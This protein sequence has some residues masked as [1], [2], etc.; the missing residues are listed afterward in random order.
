MA[1]TEI[2]DEPERRARRRRS[3]GER[4]RNAILREAGQLATVEGIN[5]LSISRLAEAV[6][7]SKSGLFAHFGSKEELQIATIEAAR[8][9]FTAQVIDPALAAPTGLDRLRQLVENFLRYVEGGLYPGGCFFASVAAEMA[10][11]PGPVR[12]GAVQVVDEFSAAGGDGRSRR[13]GR[14]SDRSFRGRR[15]ARIRTRRLHV[16]RQRAVRSQPGFGT[17]RQGTPR[18]GRPDHGGGYRRGAA[19]V[20]HHSAPSDRGGFP[21]GSLV[22]DPSRHQSKAGNLPLSPV[23]TLPSVPQRA[24]AGVARGRRVPTSSRT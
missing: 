22:R 19:G 7:M 21:Q 14:G 8:A 20:G 11:R 12:D 10:M 5:G 2:R 9:V 4:S 15:A 16:P 17:D 24:H 13:P 18:A 6:G 1:D 23:P 3:D